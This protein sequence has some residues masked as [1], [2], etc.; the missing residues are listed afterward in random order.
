MPS[1]YPALL[2]AETAAKLRHVAQVLR[3]GRPYNGPRN[4]DTLTGG[5]TL[6]QTDE[7]TSYRRLQGA[8]RAGSLEGR[9]DYRPDRLR[10][11]HPS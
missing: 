4:L 3:D 1:I 2:D 10:E 5:N 9:E 11:R 7:K 8:G 6:D